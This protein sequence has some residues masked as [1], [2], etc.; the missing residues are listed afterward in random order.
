MSTNRPTLLIVLLLTTCVLLSSCGGIRG[1]RV[2]TG[3]GN[4]TNIVDTRQLAPIRDLSG[5]VEV[6]NVSST[7]AFAFSATDLFSRQAVRGT[8][9]FEGGPAII[10]FVVP[11]CPVCVSEGPLLGASAANNP[12][13]TYVFVHSGGD[14]DSYEGYVTSSE[15][16]ASNVVHLDDSAGWIWTRFGVIQQPTSLLVDADGDVTQSLGSLGEEGLARAISNLRK[17]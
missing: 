13:V 3:A 10:T 16:S 7:E 17:S 15:L 6:T 11:G 2:V 12:D 9:L 8:D 1:E 5:A 14:A 4:E